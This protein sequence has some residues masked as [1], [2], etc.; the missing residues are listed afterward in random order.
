MVLNTFGRV[1]F[2]IDDSGSEPVRVAFE[3]WAQHVLVGA[4]L[5]DSKGGASAT[6]KRDWGALKRF[7]TTHR[8]REVGYVVKS[9][10]DLRGALC[11]FTAAFSRVVGE[12]GRGDVVVREQLARLEAAAKRQDTAAVAAEAL[13]TVR[14]VGESIDRRSERHR[15]Q[16]VELA[17]HVRQLSDQLQTAKKAGETDGLTQV[18]NRACFD[19][20]L[21]RTVDLAAFS[22]ADVYLMMV[23]VDRFKQ[24]NDAL[25]H[26]AGDAALRAVADRLIRTFPRRGDLVARYGGD[27]FA[28]VVRD[29]RGD[30]ARM[31]AE[32]LVVA[33]RT[34]KAEHLGKQ[35]PLSVSV[36]IAA[37]KEADTCDTWIARA[38]AALYR[39]KQEGRDRWLETA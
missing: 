39:A 17:G 34:T 7:V 38:D 1:S 5:G 23:D 9:L 11:V 29:V 31:L 33:M 27:E 3:R 18:P 24:T 10:E 15:A 36:G 2:A 14:V 16:V 26:G 12:D 32:R 37:R 20:F 25:G 21:A 22:T 6:G 35:I 8:Q 19:E 28:V 30:E 4:P 13:L